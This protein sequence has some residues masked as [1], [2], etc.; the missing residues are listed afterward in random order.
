MLLA[1]FEQVVAE[2]TAVDSFRGISR[3]VERLE[4]SAIQAEPLL[5]RIPGVVVVDT[6]GL[7]RS[8]T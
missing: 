2:S 3:P 5:L 1:N 6:D 7:R 8:K 4:H